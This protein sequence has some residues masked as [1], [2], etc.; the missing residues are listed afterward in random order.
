V[1]KR[2]ENSSASVG[3]GLSQPTV[4]AALR[5]AC[6]L[7][8]FDKDFHLA[9]ADRVHHHFVIALRLVGVPWFL[10]QASYHSES[11]PGSPDIREAQ[12]ASWTSGV[13]IE[14]PDTDSLRAEYRSGVHFNGEGLRK[15]G[16][17]WAD[18][19]GPWLE[20]RLSEQ[21]SR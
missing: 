17:M 21:P 11:D 1:C 10:A 19:V 18:T 5:D 6:S 3:P 2:R 13:A 12:R 7:R 16:R 8:L 15:H 9:G 4:P 20:Q 14:G